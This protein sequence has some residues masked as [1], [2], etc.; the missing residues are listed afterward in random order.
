MAVPKE[1][2]DYFSP[3]PPELLIKIISRLSITSFTDLSQASPFFRKF[4]KTNAPTI[5]NSAIQTRHLDLAKALNA[6]VIHRWLIP[7]DKFGDGIH[8]AH[9]A[10]RISRGIP[11]KSLSLLAEP[12]PQFLMLLDQAGFAWELRESIRETNVITNDIS[13]KER[14]WIEH[15]EHRKSSLYY[16]CL[17]G[18]RTSRYMWVVKE[19]CRDLMWYYKPDVTKSG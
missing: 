16:M 6:T 10:T 9:K 15:M 19:D 18:F 14:N 12:G 1:E 13:R 3:L 5:C 2:R 17:T 8:K 11:W 4:F 7:V